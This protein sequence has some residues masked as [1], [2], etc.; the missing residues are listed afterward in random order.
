[1]AFEHYVYSGTKRL[2]CG[3]TTGSCAALASQAATKM[4]LGAPDVATATILTPKGLSVTADVL[5]ISRGEGRV[6]CAIRK[7]GGDDVDATDGMLVY[8]E[9]RVVECGASEADGAADGGA[10]PAGGCRVLID[11]GVGVGRVTMPGLDQPVGNA[12]INHVPR[13]MIEREVQAVC[14]DRGFEGTIGIVISAPEGV[15]IAGKTFNPRLGIEGG[16]S[17]LGT[18]G[19]VEPQSLQALLD[20]IRTEA[21]AYA[22]QSSRIVITPG[23]YGEAFLKTYELPKGVPELKFSNFLGDTLDELAID[24]FED[25]LLVS[26]IGKLAKV[27]GGIMNTHSRT[28]DCR[29]EIFCAH[30]AC[31]GADT[32]TCRRILGAATSDACLDIIEEAGLTDAV[33]ASLADAIQ[34]RL[35]HRV[36]GAYRIG[37]V[38][39][40]NK[41]GFLFATEPAQQIMA[42]WNEGGEVA[43]SGAGKL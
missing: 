7:D 29:T 1:M 4:L 21:R 19:I 32:E 30:A 26:H 38:T 41:S 17:I 40:S 15:E 42:D 31:A 43:G 6:S 20:S 16:V 14:A 34:D 27:A 35:E 23:S 2:R 33:L 5:E 25:V 18:T 39:F 11:G 28:A 22:A 13:E 9:A 36:A 24:G 12:A 37:A 3:Y 10:E 8:S